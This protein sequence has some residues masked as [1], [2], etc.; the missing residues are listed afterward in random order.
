MCYGS[1]KISSHV[2]HKETHTGL[3]VVRFDGQAES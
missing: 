2:A 3:Q 1:I